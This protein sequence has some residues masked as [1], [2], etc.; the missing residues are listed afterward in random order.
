MELRPLPHSA[1][2]PLPWPSAAP[3]VYVVERPRATVR[4]RVRRRRVSAA[5]SGPALVRR[6]PPPTGAYPQSP[7]QAR[8]LALGL[9]QHH[10]AAR[11]GVAR[12]TVAR[13]EAWAA[14]EQV[15]LFPET[16]AKIEAALAE[17]EREAQ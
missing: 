5:V 14:G 16:A 11:A 2:G 10:V 8:R 7:Y 13:A 3:T 1:A 6:V 12:S 15:G 4:V 9:K 17:L